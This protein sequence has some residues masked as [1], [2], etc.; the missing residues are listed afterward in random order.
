MIDGN[1][2]SNFGA[3][4]EV[5]ALIA[6]TKPRVAQADDSSHGIRSE[7]PARQSFS[8]NR[9]A[10]PSRDITESEPQARH[11]TA[12]D[13]A[14]AEEKAKFCR[15]FLDMKALNYSG[16][17]ASGALGKP[18]SWFSV[19]VPIFEREGVAGLLP[20]RR[21]CGAK[22]TV[23]PDLPAWFIP[24][25]RFFYLLTNRQWNKGS[26]PEALRRT[27]SLPNLPMG[28]TNK[29]RAKFLNYLAP[30]LGEASSPR[31]S[32]SEG[33]GV[34][35]PECP[36]QIRETILARQKLGQPLLTERLLRLI[37]AGEIAVRSHR[38]PRAA[39]LDYVQSPGSLMLTVDE[40]TGM[41]RYIEPG[42][43]AT[44]DDATKNFPCCVAGLQKPGDKCFDRWG[45]FASRFQFLLTVDHRTTFITGF[46]HTARPRA[47]YRAEDAVAALQMAFMGNGIPKAVVLENGVFAA[48]ILTEMLTGLGVRII[49]A[50]SPHQ[51]VVENV[52]SKLW[53]RLSVQFPGVDVGR[54]MGEG[55][56]ASRLLESC[57]DGANDPR[58][59]Y[60]MLEVVIAVL[61][62]V[63][64]EHNA[65]PV[66]GRYGFFSPQELFLAKAHLNSRP[67][68]PASAWRFSPTITDPLKVRSTIMQTSVT[69][70]PGFSQKFS[71]NIMGVANDFFGAS[72]RLYFNPF[73]PDCTAKIVLA[74][75]HNGHPA[76]TV[77]G[78]AEMHDR[79]A[80][81]S[82]R[83]LHY[84]EQ[85]DNGL[86]VTKANAQAVHRYSQAVRPGRKDGVSAVE[87][88]DG[89]GNAVRVGVSKAEGASNIQHSTPNIEFSKTETGQKE[90]VS[91]S[92]ATE[93]SK[94]RTQNLEAQAEETRR[95]EEENA[96]L[97]V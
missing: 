34:K 19:N 77:L 33:E 48:K 62:E 53:T 12:A 94:L 74:D 91:D 3:R 42:E 93:N 80:R 46:N 43:M 10:A 9:M 64:A 57:R 39:W 17:Q 5:T 26:T 89:L 44:I 45:V 85:I 68:D 24:A 14:E 27:I 31:P 78:D 92:L 49:R 52:F 86:A 97:F 69:L 83:W 81:Y 30:F 37:T 50:S 2:F 60:P 47:S 58:K 8:E 54:F 65:T 72:V 59:Y 23:L 7:L 56:E 67:F 66:N 96:H 71:F 73:A 36:E 4:A 82:R 28:W 16:N 15:A 38:S 13:W 1:P 11:Y 55:E 79:E 6:N 41:E 25:A 20:K 87:A 18:A 22:A 70:L 84:S 88:R 51:K 76:G 40:I 61:R 75:G 90:K 35:L 95:F 29:E 63:I 32:P 21:E